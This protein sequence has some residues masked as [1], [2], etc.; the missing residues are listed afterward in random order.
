MIGEVWVRNVAKVH[1]SV[2]TDCRNEYLGDYFDRAQRLTLSRPSRS[3]P[4]SP[5][6]AFQ[7]EGPMESRSSLHQRCHLTI[8]SKLRVARSKCPMIYSKCGG[9][10]KAPSN[11]R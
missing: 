5:W 1:A 3:G 2:K 10:I 4:L 6:P 8:R 7:R 9:R 11:R